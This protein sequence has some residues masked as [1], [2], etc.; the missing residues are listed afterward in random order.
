M[1][2]PLMSEQQSDS[3]RAMAAVVGSGP[4]DAAFA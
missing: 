2:G 3:N 1:V 4:S